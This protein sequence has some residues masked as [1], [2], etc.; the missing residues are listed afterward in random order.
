[1]FES[2]DDGGCVIIDGQSTWWTRCGEW[3][4]WWIRRRE[5]EDG[6]ER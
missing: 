5:F 2:E 6:N 1:M 4:G 3:T